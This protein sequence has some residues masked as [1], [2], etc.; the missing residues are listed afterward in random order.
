MSWI[1]MRT[2][3]AGDPATLIIADE[4]NIPIEHAIGLLHKFWCWADSQLTDGNAPTV[5][6]TRIDRFIGVTG[7]TKAIESAGWLV[8][9]EH[10]ITIPNFDNWMSQSAKTRLKTQQ[11][12]NKHRVKLCNA[13]T[14][15]KALLQDS[16]G[17]YSK[18]IPP[19]PQGGESERSEKKRKSNKPTPEQEAQAET[20]YHAYPIHKGK[21]A[22]IKAILKAISELSYEPM[23]ARVQSYAQEV[24]HKLG[25]DDERF[26]PMPATWFNQGRYLDEKPVV[27]DDPYRTAGVDC[28]IH[29]KAGKYDGR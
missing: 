1:A 4:L 23:L 9:N 13:P 7:F 11:R 3:L 12:V 18:K 15:T 22:A 2:D 5:T 10:G 27:A 8:R 21:K 28:R 26:I 17:Q 14:V 20:I 19:T 25:T 6:E 29:A 24:A 16:T